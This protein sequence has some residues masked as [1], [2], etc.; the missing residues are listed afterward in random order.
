MTWK[1]SVCSENHHYVIHGRLH[2]RKE[3]G[4]EFTS[5]IYPKKPS[6]IHLKTNGQ[7]EF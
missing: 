1:N 5:H 2:W 7:N 6:M 4:M 3:G